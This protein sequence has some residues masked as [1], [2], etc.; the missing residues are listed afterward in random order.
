MKPMIQM[1]I[2]ASTDYSIYI[3]QVL[4][5]DTKLYIPY[6]TENIVIIT[7]ENVDKYYSQ[8]V[9]DSIYR[10]DRNIYKYVIKP[11]EAS[12]SMQEATNILNFLAENHI[13]SDDLLIALGGGVVGDLTGFVAS[14]YLRG[15]NFLQIPTTF[16]AAIDSSVGGKTA[17][18]LEAGKNLAG[19]IVQPIAVLIDY[20]CFKTL[21]NQVFSDGVAESI[22]MGLLFDKE[23]F[24]RFS[25][26]LVK[27]DSYDM[28][29]IIKNSIELKKNIIEEDEFDKESR[30]LLNFGHTIAHAIEKRSNYKI[31]HGQAVAIG[32]CTMIRALERKGRLEE[33]ITKLVEDTFSK[34]SLPIYLE[35]PLEEIIPFMK[36]DKKFKDGKINITILNGLGRS[37]L[38]TLTY[39]ELVEFISTGWNLFD[40]ENYAES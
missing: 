29:Q 33:G 22:K 38:M 20:D 17:V 3:Q 18:N 21:D 16:L 36:N 23:L 1:D 24:D 8:T 11:G 31:S 15:I 9:F 2:N 19:R 14:I 28:D 37:S 35:N 5:K 4:L 13:Q 7:D 39:E 27:K 30:Q 12:K 26:G 6:E 34:Y 10:E 40:D 32:I 25:E